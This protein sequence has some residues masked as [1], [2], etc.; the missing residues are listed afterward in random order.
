MTAAK[1]HPGCEQ[2]EEYFSAISGDVY[3]QYDYRDADGVLFSTVKRTLDDC[4]AMR[5]RWLE[6]RRGKQVA[7]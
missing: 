6:W 5:D 4:R 1:L 7:P 3:I 2:S